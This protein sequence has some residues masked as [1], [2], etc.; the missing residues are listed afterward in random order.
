MKHGDTVEF[1]ATD[2]DT[3]IRK[4][5]R[6][7]TLGAWPPKR[8]G[9]TEGSRA[10][11]VNPKA[12]QKGIEKGSKRGRKGTQQLR[13]GGVRKAAKGE[14]EKKRELRKAK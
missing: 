2:G 11:K 6:L 7:S 4:A 12:K 5:R 1:A 9:A 3:I 10:N 13:K 14:I 8:A